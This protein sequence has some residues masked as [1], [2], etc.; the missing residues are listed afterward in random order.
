VAAALGRLAFSGDDP[1]AGPAAAAAVADRLAAGTTDTA[2]SAA[3]LAT[4]ALGSLAFSGDDP[5]AGPVA[6][7]AVADKMAAGTTDTAHSAASLATAALGSLAFSGDDPLAGPAAAAGG[8]A[9]GMAAAATIE[10]LLLE[11]PVCTLEQA[12]EAEEAVLG[13]ARKAA[14]AAV[15]ARVS[16]DKCSASGQLSMFSKHQAR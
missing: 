10:A 1:L 6:A 9:E 7:A 4:A 5:L 15:A 2:H 8:D 12:L 14:A 11:Q 16:S 13:A 3:S